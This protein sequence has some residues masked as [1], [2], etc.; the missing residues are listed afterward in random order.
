MMS[1]HT[2]GFAKNDARIDRRSSRSQSYVPRQDANDE[3]NH[4]EW[5]TSPI[6]SPEYDEYDYPPC[7]DD[8]S[9][10]S[11]AAQ[12][13]TAYPSHQVSANTSYSHQIP[14]SYSTEN[15]H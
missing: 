11:Y 5:P 7:G 13:S 6:E 10:Y 12:G 9:Q 15:S 1:P 14:A 3:P 2:V 4:V 8:T